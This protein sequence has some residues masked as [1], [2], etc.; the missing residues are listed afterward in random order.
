MAHLNTLRA[1]IYL[2]E[3]DMYKL[4]A[5]SYARLQIDGTFGLQEVRRFTVAPESAQIPPGLIDL[6]KYKGLRP[7]NFYVAVC[8]LMVG[9]TA[10]TYSCDTRSWSFSSRVET[11]WSS[12]HSFIGTGFSTG[13][14]TGSLA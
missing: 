1:H 5:D 7:P 10:S 14:A 13:I 11:W 6:T 2:S 12:L 9:A 8:S 3:H 4:R